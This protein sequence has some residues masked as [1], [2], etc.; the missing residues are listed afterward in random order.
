M[1][2]ILIGLLYFALSSNS[3][4]EIWYEIPMK[5]NKLFFVGYELMPALQQQFGKWIPLS[6]Y[7]IKSSK[8]YV[9]VSRVG[10]VKNRMMV[11]LKLRDEKGAVTEINHS[12]YYKGADQELEAIVNYEN[13][14]FVLNI[15]YGGGE[16]RKLWIA[17]RESMQTL[18]KEVS[19]SKTVPLW[20]WDT[21]VQD[22]AK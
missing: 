7:R 12:H 9:S 3:G 21:V 13:G 14:N 2:F 6:V 22:M 5:E 10:R 1:K 11:S 8:I 19:L 16:K 18:K 15:D 17:F 4:A 20:N